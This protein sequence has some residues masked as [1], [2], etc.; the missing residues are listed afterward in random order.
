VLKDKQ[1]E[2]LEKRVF[3]KRE[4]I[5]THGHENEQIEKPLKHIIILLKVNF[6]EEGIEA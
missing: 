2:A 4:W 3:T 5:E 1:V 6:N